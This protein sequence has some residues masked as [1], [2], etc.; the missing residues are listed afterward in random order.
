M[1]SKTLQFYFLLFLLGASF[2]LAVS[3]FWPFLAALALALIFA[4]VL[5]PLHGKIHARMSEMPGIASLLT[6]TVGVLGILLPL[7]ALGVLLVSQAEALYVTLTQGSVKAYLQ[8]PLANLQQTISAYI[9]GTHFLDGFSSDLDIYLQRGLEWIIQNMG[10]AF[11]KA[12]AL[13]I[14]FF[15]F[16]FALYYLLRDG[17]A[18]KRTVVRLS[19]LPDAQDE[20]ILDRLELAI[21]SV[22]KGNLS[23]A[24]IQGVL[25]AIGFTI[26]GIPNGILWGTVAA[27]GALIPGVGTTLVFLPAVLILFFTGQVFSAVGLLV[28]GIL[29]VGLVDNF[30]GPRLIGERMHMHPLFILLAVLGGIAL[31][32]P[33]GVFLGPLA[34]SLFVT[35][36]SLYSEISK[37]ERDRQDG[38]IT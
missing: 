24:L 18:L 9:P 26:F 29:A 35:L 20:A 10:A 1:D 12:A 4:V 33:I 30:L 36:L 27:M 37:H 13:L 25:T 7:V 21:N 16:F 5:R 15:V 6:V 28:W 11:S 8:V 31:F 38:M 32:G 22:I 14:N 23:I 19:P 2:I 3:I 34:V 17:A